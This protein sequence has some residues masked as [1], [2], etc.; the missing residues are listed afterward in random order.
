MNNNLIGLY[1]ASINLIS[2]I[3][4]SI[5]KNAAKKK[6]RRIPERT[7]LFLEIMG[8]VF[9]IFLLMYT[10]H[11]KNRKFSYYIWT[12]V[13]LIAWVAII[14]FYNSKYFITLNIDI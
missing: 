4:F 14:L 7:L 9:A 2:G 13:V 5:D 11:H 6:H 10:L 1:F 8:G 3:V 12:W